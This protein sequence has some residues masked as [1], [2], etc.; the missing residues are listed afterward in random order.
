M[1]KYL[2]YIFSIVL[3]FSL[4]ACTKSVTESKK[5]EV[6]AVEQIQNSEEEK[7][8]MPVKGQNKENLKEENKE[9]P[10]PEEKHDLKE[11]DKEKPKQEEKSNSKEENVK[12]K[13]VIVIDPGHSS[14]GTRWSPRDCFQYS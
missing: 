14:R 4:S 10:K 8:T 6:K 3:L 9:T 7:V 11:E 13:K 12:S 2:V 1:K 5:E